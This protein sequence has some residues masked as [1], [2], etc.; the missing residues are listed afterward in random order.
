MRL[1]LR[2]VRIFFRGG[3]RGLL[4]PR[5]HTRL[6]LHIHILLQPRPRTHIHRQPIKLRDILR[7]DPPTPQVPNLPQR[8]HQRLKH[9]L[10][11]IRVVPNELVDRV[12]DRRGVLL[13][14]EDLQV[15][16]GRED[17]EERG[18][19]GWARGE[20]VL[21]GLVERERADNV[22][23]GLDHLEVGLDARFERSVDRLG[24]LGL[25]DG[26][27]RGRFVVY[28]GRDDVDC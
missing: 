13:V 26:G 17:R 28:E 12:P 9:A 1:R 23:H 24:E 20:L 8:R 11:Q 25:L 3:R 5:L 19:D 4:T 21:T 2:L 15:L 27:Q 10:P 14:D 22:R 7:R 18:D 16:L 6:I